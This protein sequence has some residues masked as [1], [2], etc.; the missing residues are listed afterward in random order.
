M[1]RASVVLVSLT[2]LVGG[3]VNAVAASGA[4]PAGPTGSGDRLEVY[5]ATVDAAGM[6]ALGEAGVDR[7]HSAQQPA[8][9]GRARLEVV[10][11]PRQAR[12]LG[13]EG[14]DLALKRVD[15]V[16]ASREMSK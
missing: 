8:K 14:V 16:P 9:G 11:T 13:R 2:A 10:L 3:M 1:R 6:E 5:T 7:G 4:P 15:G 12:A